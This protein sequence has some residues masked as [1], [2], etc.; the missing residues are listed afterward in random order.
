MSTHNTEGEGFNP[1]IHTHLAA[2]HCRLIL[3]CPNYMPES[4]KRAICG[5]FAAITPQQ[6]GA[7]TT[8]ASVIGTSCVVATSLLL[9]QGYGGHVLLRQGY[10]GHVL[11][12]QAYGG[13]V[14]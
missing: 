11:L 7:A 1:L 12:R 13:H 4:C 9:R 14:C 6:S 10:G 3:A 8:S 2:G 5:G